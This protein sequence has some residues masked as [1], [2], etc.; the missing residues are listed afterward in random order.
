MASAPI[1]FSLLE[2]NELEEEIRLRGITERGEIAIRKLNELVAQEELGTRP[3]PLP[4]NSIRLNT[5]LE[6]CRGKFGAL[7]SSINSCVESG[8]DL[9][10]SSAV[11]RLWHLR[12]KVSRLLEV[13]PTA[14]AVST[15]LSEIT[16]LA[17][18]LSPSAPVDSSVPLLNLTTTDGAVGVTPQLSQNALSDFLRRNTDQGHV[19]PS[20]VR[21]QQRTN[22]NIFPD[23]PMS[24]NN[25]QPAMYNVA[26]PNAQIPNDFVRGQQFGANVDNRAGPQPN[27]NN[28]GHAMSRWPIRFPGSTKIP[29]DEFIFRV[30]SLA[31]GENVPLP[32][33]MLGL[34]FLLEK[35]PSDFY[36]NFLRKNPAATWH[37]CKAVL[38][39]RYATLD[40]DVEIRRAIADRRQSPGEEFGEFSLAIE[41]LANRLRRAMDEGEIIDYLRQNMSARLQTALLLHPT[42]TIRELQAHCRRFE[43][44]W[45]VQSLNSRRSLGRVHELEAPFNSFHIQRPANAEDF[46][47]FSETPGTE[48]VSANIDIPGSVDSIQPPENSR[49]V[50]PVARAEYLICWNCRDIGHTFAECVAIRT[51]FCY[52][53]G[54]ANVYKPQCIHCNSGNARRG[55]LSSGPGRPNPFLRPPMG[56][57]SPRR[58]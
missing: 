27:R 7:Q 22:R 10:D 35:G 5:E 16:N 49:P 38:S 34:H 33:L 6:E 20:S 47:P 15:L 12:N 26:P 43:R 13:Y 52:G 23:A 11:V 36:W 46:L 51:V 50:P 48:Q 56:A 55:G 31:M 39:E 18:R 1:D 44:L 32:S 54:T 19:N 24:D 2:R 42:Y 41:S 3:R 14:E 9:T 17:T 57:Q 37:Q 58:Q 21:F 40:T 53:C 4:S 29:I 25:V 28:L 30:E 8:K 45:E